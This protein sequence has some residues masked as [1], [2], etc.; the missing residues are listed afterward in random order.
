MKYHHSLLLD[1]LHQAYEEGKRIIG[2]C[3]GTYVLAAAGLLKGKKATTPSIGHGLMIF[4]SI[5]RIS[6]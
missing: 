6:H 2:L 5:I 4:I 3:L 1:A